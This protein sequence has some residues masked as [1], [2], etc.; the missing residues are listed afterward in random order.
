ML[1]FILKIYLIISIICNIISNCIIYPILEVKL[2]KEGYINL[3]DISMRNYFL[4]LLFRGLIFFIPFVNV[5]TTYY[6]LFHTKDFYD[7][8]KEH[9]SKAKTDIEKIKD[10]KV[11]SS[12]CIETIKKDNVET[13]SLKSLNID[14][15]KFDNMSEKE[16]LE[17]LKKIFQ[18]NPD[19][20]IDSNIKNEGKKLSNKKK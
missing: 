8:L 18:E 12:E 9:Y 15:T 6:Y 16:Q 14:E 10:E 2:D 19:L 11:N 20:L 17:Y 4:E 3:K 5:T 1:I 7:E 13:I